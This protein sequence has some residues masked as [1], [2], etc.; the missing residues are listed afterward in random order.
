M[1][2]AEV[3][4]DPRRHGTRARQSSEAGEE[5]VVEYTAEEEAI[6]V[7]EE[8]TI[9]M[10]V[11][12]GATRRTVT[13]RRRKSLPERRPKKSQFR[14]P[15]RACLFQTRRASGKRPGLP[16]AEAAE[17]GDAAGDADAGDVDVDEEAS[18][19]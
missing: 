9:E 7:V 15:T 11:E 8:E 12:E 10:A 4:R 1:E 19:V 5:V 3:D 6:A 18:K 2:P 13:T 14:R 16:L 17:A